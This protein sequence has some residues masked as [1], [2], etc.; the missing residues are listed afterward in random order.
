MRT[1]E[2][3]MAGALAALMLWTPAAANAAVSDGMQNFFNSFDNA[4]VT[5]TPAGAY[6]SQSRGYLTGGALSVRVPMQTTQL[7]S[8][9]PPSFNMGCNG[10]DSHFGAISHV[11]LDRFIQLLTQLGTGAT[12]GFAFQLAMN[13]LSPSV[14]SVLSQIESVIRYVNQTANVSPCQLGKQFGE[15]LA[16]Y[17]SGRSA[18]PMSGQRLD[19][20]RGVIRDTMEKVEQVAQENPSTLAAKLAGQTQNGDNWDLRG[21]IVWDVLDKY[22]S[23]MTTDERLLLM[24]A[25]GT[26][27]VDNQGTATDYPSKVTPQDLVDVKM[28][29]QVRVYTCNDPNAGCLSLGDSTVSNMQGFEEMIRQRL[30]QLVAQINVGEQI[31]PALQQWIDQIPY[32]VLRVLTGQRDQN[33]RMEYVR[34]M[35]RL[36][37]ARMTRQF[38]GELTR[39]LKHGISQYKKQ[40]PN[41]PGDASKLYGEIDRI[42]EYLEQLELK[43]SQMEKNY[44]AITTEVTKQS[45][46]PVRMR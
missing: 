19:A 31:P 12:L 30:E 42:N 1:K 32:P 8:I 3:L 20:I 35:S 45:T 38:L 40:K 2:R 28:G 16:N 22:F 37:A 25:V 23:W 43:A 10:F 14:A 41:W 9:T 15:E 46:V 5:G 24:S 11:S 4:V 18:H 36:I 21:N 39:D 27:V 7:L 13:N 29:Q 17:A 6:Q 33:Q 34:N 26:I 44:L